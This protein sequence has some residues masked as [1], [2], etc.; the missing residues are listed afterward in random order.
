MHAEIVGIFTIPSYL[1][2]AGT[3]P[4]YLLYTLYHIC[5]ILENSREIAQDLLKQRAHGG[6]LLATLGVVLLTDLTDPIDGWV[7]DLLGL[8][9]RA[10]S[11]CPGLLT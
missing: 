3:W 7:K 8:P 1:M 2:P 5:A 4:V 11:I 9:H 6:K 10:S